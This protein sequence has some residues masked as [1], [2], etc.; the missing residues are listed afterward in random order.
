MVIPALKRG[1]Y[2]LKKQVDVGSRPGGGKHLVDVVAS[3]Q[4]GK[5]LLISTKWQQVG[6]TA[7]QKVPYEVICLIKALKNNDSK[8]EKAYL[9]L[10][11]SGWKLRNFYVEG[12]LKDYLKNSDLVTII[13]LE[14]F[15]A[16]ANQRKL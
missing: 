13:T 2:D 7:E 16:L 4:N 6:G 8:Y 9:V 1:G 5:S 3:S 12:G 11:G 10:G 14:S 15:I